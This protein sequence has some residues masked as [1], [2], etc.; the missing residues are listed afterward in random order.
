V[1][2]EEAAGRLGEL[3]LLVVE[4]E[5]QRQARARLS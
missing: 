1:A 5:L 3:L 2:G 4:V